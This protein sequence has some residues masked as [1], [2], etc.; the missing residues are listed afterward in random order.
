MP[1]ERVLAGVA[2]TWEEVEIFNLH[3]YNIQNENLTYIVEIFH[4]AFYTLKMNL[5]E[6]TGG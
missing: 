5:L 2:H 3:I 6:S 4:S 1:Q